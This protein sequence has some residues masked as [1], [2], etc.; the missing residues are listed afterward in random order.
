MLGDNTHMMQNPCCTFE[1]NCTAA[2]SDIW[3]LLLDYY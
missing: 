2:V 1:L 3:L